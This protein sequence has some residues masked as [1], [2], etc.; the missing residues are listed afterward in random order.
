[1][2]YGSVAKFKTYHQE[3]GRTVSWTDP[4][5]EA[6]LLVASEWLDGAY[7]QLWVGTP[8]GGF[9]QERLWP[10][11][12]ATTNTVPPYTFTDSEIPVL[13]ENATYEAAFRQATSPGSLLVDFTPS[14]YKSVRVEGAIQAEYMNFFQSSEVQ[15]QIAVVQTLMYPL[16]NASAQAFFSILS[17]PVTRV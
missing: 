11:T 1:M 15:T 10:R 6:A 4:V 13:V 7:A 16:I 8:T 17:G 5:I 9:T 2:F 3:R 12:D 14:K